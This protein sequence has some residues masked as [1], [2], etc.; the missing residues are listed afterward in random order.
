MLEI[1]RECQIS[2][3]INDII[4]YLST[5]IVPQEFSTVQKKN[6]VVRAA[7]YQP[8][9]GNLYNM[10]T[11]SIIRRCVLEHERPIILVEAH[12]VI[13]RGNYVGKSTSQKVLCTGFW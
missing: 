8:I 4:E 9:V 10:G 13:A 1:C 12:E 7:D 6:P 3:N 11:N 5:R 2:L